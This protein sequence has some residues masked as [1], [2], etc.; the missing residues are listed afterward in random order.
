[1]WVYRQL[2]A[3][4]KIAL[5]R[6]AWIYR[7]ISVTF[8]R[9]RSL[10]RMLLVLRCS[11]EVGLPKNQIGK[12]FHQLTYTY[13]HQLGQAA[14]PNQDYSQIHEIYIYKYKY[15][16]YTSAIHSI[17]S[18]ILTSTNQASQQI[19]IRTIHRFMYLHLK[20]HIQ[21]DFFNRPPLKVEICK[22]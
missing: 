18:P 9:P 13:F 16:K 8:S 5:A 20:I 11:W 4:P 14:N 21:G 22:T 19:Q 2:I 1:M 12:P 15:T 17:Y 10:M 6:Q 7:N 3:M